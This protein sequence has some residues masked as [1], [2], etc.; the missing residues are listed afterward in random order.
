MT[1]LELEVKKAKLL[2]IYDMLGTKLGTKARARVKKEVKAE[3]SRI[4]AEIAK[5]KEIV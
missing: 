4:E 2:I 3:V 5:L 1:R